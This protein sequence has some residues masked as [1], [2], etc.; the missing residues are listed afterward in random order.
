[1]T[2]NEIGDLIISQEAEELS[3]GNYVNR[4]EIR[5]YYA[6][7]KCGNHW[8][9]ISVS[10]ADHHSGRITVAELDT[11]DPTA[12]LPGVV[13][14]VSCLATA[15][16]SQTAEE[17]SIHVYFNSAGIEG[18]WAEFHYNRNWY[19][20]SVSHVNVPAKATPDELERIADEFLRQ[21]GTTYRRRR[22]A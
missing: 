7:V 10:H 8:C 12:L 16:K 15:L 2:L 5:G 6:Q 17:T 4:R 11:I 1:M 20:I 19:M 9:K 3:H 14:P 18:I 22:T 21:Q 13:I